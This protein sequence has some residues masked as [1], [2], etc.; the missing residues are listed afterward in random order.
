MRDSYYDPP[1]PRTPK[2]GIDSKTISLP[3]PSVGDYPDYVEYE[4]DILFDEGSFFSAVLTWEYRPRADANGEFT[5]FEDVEIKIKT[6]H[7][8]AEL[9]SELEG[10]WLK[11]CEDDRWDS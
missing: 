3:V 10:Q 4:A 1:E 7:L 11:A 6:E 8:P 9:R 2:G 5:Q